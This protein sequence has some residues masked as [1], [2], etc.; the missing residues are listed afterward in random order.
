VIAGAGIRDPARSRNPL[1]G[2][3]LLFCLLIAGCAPPP[4]TSVKPEPVQYAETAGAAW[5]ACR[6]RMP[7]ET[8]TKPDWHV[9]LILAH[10]VVA[11]VL[12]KYRNDVVF[13]RFHRRAGP[14]EAG[15]QFSFLF[16]ADDEPASE[17]AA[18]IADSPWLARLQQAGV[19]T[20]R[21]CADRGG[22]QGPEVAASSDP[23][24]NEDVQRAWPHFIMGVSE[25]WLDLIRQG[26]NEEVTQR[27]PET[28]QLPLLLDEYQALHER[29]TARWR[30]Q[31]RHA[32]LHHLNA[33]FGYSPLL[34]RY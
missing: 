4:S 17:L 18:A 24:W 11:P 29:V 21:S 10:R 9:D 13:W 25:F 31:G 32:L 27:H 16:Y 20:W 12:E 34:M 5:H 3:G 19:V 28:A 23:N 33:I 22:W 14:G 15:H 26:T 8:G 6:F 1:A 30:E 2:G 7:Y